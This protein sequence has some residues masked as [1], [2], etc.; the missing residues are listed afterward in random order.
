MVEAIQGGRNHRPFGDS[1]EVR[2]VDV[3]QVRTI[4]KRRYVSGSGKDEKKRNAAERQAWSRALKDAREGSLI[5][6][7]TLPSGIELL[8]FARAADEPL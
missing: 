5:G 1:P 2:A 7:E 4:H 6:G 3:E 8:W